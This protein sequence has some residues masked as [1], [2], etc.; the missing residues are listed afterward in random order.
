MT[1]PTIPNQ[2]VDLEVGLIMMGGVSRTSF[3]DRA[4]KGLT[5]KPVKIGPRRSAIPVRE[6]D[7]LNAAQIAG[8]SDAELRALVNE[9][10]AKRSN[11]PSA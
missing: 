3:Y 11:R 7:A 1:G 9:L 6:I 4:K 5:V 2:L 10:H 8:A